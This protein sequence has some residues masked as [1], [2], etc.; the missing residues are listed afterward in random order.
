MY[1]HGVATGSMEDVS[2]LGIFDPT[3]EYYAQNYLGTNLLRLIVA[4]L[5]LLGICLFL[6]GGI[7]G[8]SVAVCLGVTKNKAQAHVRGSRPVPEENTS[9][10]ELEPT[11]RPPEPPPAVDPQQ[12]GRDQ[13]SAPPP[14]PPE[15][16]PIGAC[17]RGV[18]KGVYCTIPAKM[19]KSKAGDHFHLQSDCQSGLRHAYEPKTNVKAYDAESWFQPV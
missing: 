4:I 7:V 15:P 3:L 16:E 17:F 6:F 19:W 9:E 13:A 1:Q 5:G 10:P 18:Y 14:P 8:Y 11:A 12:A 2:A